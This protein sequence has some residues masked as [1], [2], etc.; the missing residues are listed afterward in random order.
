MRAILRRFLRRF[1][2]NLAVDMDEDGNPILP[3]FDLAQVRAA[4]RARRNPTPAQREMRRRFTFFRL[5]RRMHRELKRANA[6]HHG[7]RKDDE[8]RIRAGQAFRFRAFKGLDLSGLRSPIY[9]P[10]CI[11][12]N[13]NF[14]GAILEDSNLEGAMMVRGQGAIAIMRR[15]RLRNLDSFTVLA[16]DDCLEDNS[17]ELLEDLTAQEMLN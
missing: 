16:K 17:D 8:L 10:N 9:C 12:V 7:Q 5:F 1:A 6:K 13:C 15:S 2:L 11:F 4:F 14:D 3:D